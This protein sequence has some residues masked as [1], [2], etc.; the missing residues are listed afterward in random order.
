M[1][2]SSTAARGTIRRSRMRREAGDGTRT[3][4]IQ[5]GKLTLYQLS[6]SRR[7]YSMEPLYNRNYDLPHAAISNRRLFVRGAVETIELCRYLNPRAVTA[8]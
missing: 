6:Y 1:Q 7:T 5:L 2:R 4:D 8:R 3:R